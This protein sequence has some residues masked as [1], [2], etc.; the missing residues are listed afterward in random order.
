MDFVIFREMHVM[1]IV[2][3][4]FL[5]Y[6]LLKNISLLSMIPYLSLSSMDIL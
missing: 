1:N 4:C 2:A 3:I 5:S 6:I